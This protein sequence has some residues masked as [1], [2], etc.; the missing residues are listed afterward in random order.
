M[1]DAGWILPVHKSK[2]R[3][4]AYETYLI[5]SKDGV[6][7]AETD[8]FDN[9]RLIAA[10]PGL[11]AALEAWQRTEALDLQT[12]EFVSML[13]EARRLR[14]AAIAKARHGS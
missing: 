6:I 14:D 8:D 4:R 11:L 3:S 5:L 10:A 2:M 7:E 1:S 13:S 12:L 9:A